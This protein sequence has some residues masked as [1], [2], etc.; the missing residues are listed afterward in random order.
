MPS[1]PEAR[2]G[3]K[4]FCVSVA[5]MPSLNRTIHGTTPAFVISNIANAAIPQLLFDANNNNKEQLKETICEL[6]DS[7]FKC[8]AEVYE[9]KI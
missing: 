9:N 2:K 7:L 5:L 3:D 4:I 8:Y 6:I 1:E